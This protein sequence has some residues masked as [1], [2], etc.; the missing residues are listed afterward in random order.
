MTK[1][2]FLALSLAFLCSLGFAQSAAAQT[3]G[4]WD[5]TWYTVD[6]GGA[7]FQTGGV[8]EVG[9]TSGQHDAAVS[10]GGPWQLYSGYWPGCVPIELP[11]DM[12]CDGLVNNFDIDG[13]V[14]ALSDP[15]AYAAA[16][17][18]C[19]IQNADVDGNGL[20][21][22]FDITPFVGCIEGGGCP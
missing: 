18:N 11:A 14:L 1:S 3:G 6:G 4:P 15:A 21:N 8:F 9:S 16:F 17:P 13:F 10:A 20:I 22:N 5:L 7:T 12:N 19:N 2:N